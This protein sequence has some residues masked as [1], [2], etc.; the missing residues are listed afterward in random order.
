MMP[1]TESIPKCMMDGVGGQRVLDWI[2][3]SLARAG[4]D[5]VVFIGGYHM[6]KVVQA[7]PHLRFYE[8]TDWSNNNVLGSLMY[9][10]PE[11]D[12]TFVM[13]YSD[14]VYRSCA[15]QR[16]MASHAEIALVVDRDWRKKYV[17]RFRHLECRQ[18]TGYGGV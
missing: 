1:E 16:L 13:S 8:N 18:R 15:A 2:L 10:A 17:G 6:E 4:I 12:T 3:G 11:M 7:Y 9:A 5:D 14:I